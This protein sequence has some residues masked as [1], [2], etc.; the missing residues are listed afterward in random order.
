[1]PNTAAKEQAGQE[2]VDSDYLFGN[3]LQLP[4]FRSTHK[5]RFLDRNG[6]QIERQS[7]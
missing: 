7:E 5:E 2:D 3:F 4:T 6:G 1:M